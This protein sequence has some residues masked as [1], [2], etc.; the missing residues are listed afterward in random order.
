MSPQCRLENASFRFF[1]IPNY[2]NIKIIIFDP[3]DKSK[4]H[5]FS[6]ISLGSIG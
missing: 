4:I 6:N 2:N 1:S 3:L 5:N